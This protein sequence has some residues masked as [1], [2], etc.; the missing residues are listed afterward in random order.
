M[1]NH[2]DIKVCAFNQPH[3]TV[4]RLR[5]KDGPALEASNQRFPKEETST[6]AT[7]VS[8]VEILLTQG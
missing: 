2:L 7:D 8:W 6:A 4:S 1:M 3:Y 5:G